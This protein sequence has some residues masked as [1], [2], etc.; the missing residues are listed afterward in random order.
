MPGADFCRPQ[1]LMHPSV[2]LNTADYLIIATVV[3]SA[4]VGLLRG[5][6]REV[7]ALIHLGRCR[8]CRLALRRRLEPHLGGVLAHGAACGPGSRG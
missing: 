8:L 1:A 7:V 2:R 4:I 5:L 6:L 3:I